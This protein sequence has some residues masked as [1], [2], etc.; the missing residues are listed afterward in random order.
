MDELWPVSDMTIEQRVRLCFSSAGY[1][2][3]RHVVISVDGAAITLKGR[4]H[5]FHE[6][7][8]AQELAKHVP[9]VH[10]VKNLLEVT[11]RTDDK[12]R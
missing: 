4:V 2:G 1:H 8:L 3:L 5:S 11:G 9:E 7:Q 12:A 10:V 6:K